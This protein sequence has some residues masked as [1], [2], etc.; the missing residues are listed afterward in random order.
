MRRNRMALDEIAFRPRVLRNVV[1][2]AAGL[3]LLVFVATDLLYGL[4]AALSETR[5]AQRLRVSRVLRDK[6]LHCVQA[7][8]H[9]FYIGRF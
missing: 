2:G 1:L 4:V 5:A 3:G 7:D 8:R 9:T 6:I